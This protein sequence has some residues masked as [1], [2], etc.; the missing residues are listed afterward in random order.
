MQPKGRP[1][2]E[3]NTSKRKMKIKNHTRKKTNNLLVNGVG[4]VN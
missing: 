3:K 2:S 4:L 1:H